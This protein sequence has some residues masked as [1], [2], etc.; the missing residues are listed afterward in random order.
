MKAELIIDTWRGLSICARHFYGEL[1]LEDG[2]TF[3]IERSLT[4]QEIRTFNQHEK[5]NCEILGLSY[6]KF[7][8]YRKGDVSGR[9]DSFEDIVAALPDFV[10]KNNIDVDE[11]WYSNEN[12]VLWRQTEN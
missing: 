11:I 4:S 1:H 10:K 3:E 2:T 12:N 7:G 9:F 8:Q 6:D 5:Q